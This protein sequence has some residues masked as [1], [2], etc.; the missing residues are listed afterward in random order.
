MRPYLALFATL[1]LVSTSLAAP[2]GPTGRWAAKA[3]AAAGKPAAG[4]KVVPALVGTW[5]GSQATDR[6]PLRMVVRL[7]KDGRYVATIQGHE[8]SSTDRGAW[9][10]D[11]QRVHRRST[12][13]KTAV[14]SYRYRL[15]G[16]HLIL[17]SKD[18]TELRLSRQGG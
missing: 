18:G 11:G 15:Q 14:T 10:G 1:A 3:K 9:W 16:R 5:A 7:Q 4:R 2:A 6:A 13:R 8:Q 17:S 12:T